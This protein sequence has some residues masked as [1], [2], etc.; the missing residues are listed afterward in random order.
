MLK[1]N[2]NYLLFIQ[3]F[4]VRHY[5]CVFDSAITSRFIWAPIFCKVGKDLCAHYIAFKSPSSVKLNA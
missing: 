2:F 3:I 1:N 4:I 5:N